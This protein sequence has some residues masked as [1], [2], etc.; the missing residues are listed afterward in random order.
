MFLLAHVSLTRQQLSML[1]TARPAQCLCDST[2]PAEIFPG[3]QIPNRFLHRLMVLFTPALVA[4]LALLIPPIFRST[5]HFSFGLLQCS[6]AM[7]S[8]TV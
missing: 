3:T 2:D 6:V 4:I 7:F 5:F 1:C 8:V